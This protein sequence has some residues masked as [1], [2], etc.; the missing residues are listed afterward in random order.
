MI[1]LPLASKT[2]TSVRPNS[3]SFPQEDRRSIE[4]D[5]PSS[6][7][8]GA[9]RG[10]QV[11]LQIDAQERC[12]KFFHIFWRVVVTIVVVVV[13]TIIVVVVVGGECGRGG[14]GGIF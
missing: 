5:S 2:C 4:T 7:R 9:G 8:A 10:R 14:G 6:P 3:S 13:I 12:M 11:K 1:H